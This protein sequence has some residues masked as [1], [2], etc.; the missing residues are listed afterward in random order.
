M[1]GEARITETEVQYEPGQLIWIED[2]EFHAPRPGARSR[3]TYLLYLFRRFL[4]HH[5]GHGRSRTW[6][7]YRYCRRCDERVGDCFEEAMSAL[8]SYK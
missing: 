5:L 2:T 1:S 6:M 7:G 3:L 4:C 8:E